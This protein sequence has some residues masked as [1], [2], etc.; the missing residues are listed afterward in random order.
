MQHR[1]FGIVALAVAI[2]TLTGM[3][4]A[5]KAADLFNNMNTLQVA[6]CL[7]PVVNCPPK[8][9]LGSPST[10]ANIQTYHRQGAPPA[11]KSI[12]LGDANG[13]PI[14]GPFQVTTQPASPGFEN[15]IAAVGQTFPPGVYTVLDSQA[16][17][18]SQNASSCDAPSVPGHACDKGFAIV[19]GIA[20]AS[21]PSSS[22]T[23]CT[24]SCTLPPSTSSGPT[25]AC[26]A[27]GPASTCR[28]AAASDDNPGGGVMCTDGKNVTTC[29]CQQGCSTH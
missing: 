27:H 15:W 24:A 17:T 8:F 6:N 1:P 2:L 22:I 3:L 4:H 20:S 13:A 10:I 28:K 25:F 18:W 7:R 11:G 19:R 9:S 29:N 12:S 16:D 5:T 23:D 26:S 14:A 21:L